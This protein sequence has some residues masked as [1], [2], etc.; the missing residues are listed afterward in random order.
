MKIVAIKELLFKG[1][2]NLVI[3]SVGYGGNSNILSVYENVDWMA[4][5][6]DHRFLSQKVLF[7]IK[8]FSKPE[9]L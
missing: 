6:S 8:Q 7:T 5:H 4:C 9:R 2:W 3:V 1:M